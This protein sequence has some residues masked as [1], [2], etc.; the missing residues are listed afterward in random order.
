MVLVLI[1]AG[2][3][4]ASAAAG[5]LATPNAELFSQVESPFLEMIGPTSPFYAEGLRPKPWSER[6]FANPRLR[7]DPDPTPLRTSPGCDPQQWQESTLKSP[8]FAKVSQSI[9]AYL[10]RCEGQ[11]AEPH[12]WIGKQIYS[13][14]M[15]RHD[16]LRF[17]F[18]RSVM[19]NLPGGLKLKGYLALKSDGR[20][21]PLVL[22]RLGI[23][24]RVTEFQAERFLFLQLFEQSPFNV[25]VVEST[26]AD[27]YYLRNRTLNFGGFDEGIQNFQIAR[28]I[29]DPREPL[30][31]LVQ[32]VH[33]VAIS[34]GGNGL[35]FA[36]LLDEWGRRQKYSPTFLSGLALCPLVD[37]SATL[38]FHSLSGWERKLV[39]SWIASRWEEVG[40]LMPGLPVRT[41]LD[42]L[43]SYMAS[44]YP[45]SR[46]RDANVP[47]SAEEKEHPKDFWRLNQFWPA[48][49]DVKL[50]ILVL[51]TLQDPIVPFALNSG[52]L[53]DKAWDL[54]SSPL[55]VIPLQYGVHCSL[56]G[57]YS[58]NAMATI[59][60]TYLLSQSPG[61]QPQ[62]G[63]KSVLLAANAGGKLSQ[64]PQM[65]VI[66]GTAIENFRVKFEIGTS[67][68]FLGVLT[69]RYDEIGYRPI[70]FEENQAFLDR[71]VQ[72]NLRYHWSAVDPQHAIVTWI[73]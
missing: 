31:H 64:K 22:L 68:E 13:T 50:P 54:G 2:R 9:S 39:N 15:L 19:L 20:P 26:T 23:F 16:P 24:S 33:I 43:E 45:G 38:R 65:V 66:P 25:L 21:R 14:M 44:Q 59:E 69:L 62:S 12:Q 49:H 3:G 8:G 40:Q 51:S 27:E 36:A 28:Q 57:A 63:E 30:S 52:R 18:G 42:S 6:L 41:L 1:N 48:F 60:Q 37:M 7:F 34:M 61:F 29:Q 72:Q 55:Q 71:W 4:E 10:Q 56:P 5:D 58:W 73:Y 46:T 67:H 53:R 32:G 11:L 17:P 35:F 47:L 70:D